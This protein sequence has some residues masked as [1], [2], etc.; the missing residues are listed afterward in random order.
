MHL[1]PL[2]LGVYLE[3]T[4]VADFRT[5]LAINLPQT[6]QNLQEL[7]IPRAPSDLYFSRSTLQNKA[8]FQS[9]QGAPFG[10]E[11]Y[12]YTIYYYLI[13]RVYICNENGRKGGWL[14]RCHPINYHRDLA[15]AYHV[16]SSNIRIS[17]H[18]FETLSTPQSY[19]SPSL[20]ASASCNPKGWWRNG[21]LWKAYKWP[22]V[23]WIIL[24]FPE[25]APCRTSS[26]TRRPSKRSERSSNPTLAGYYVS[27]R[28]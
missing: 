13:D 8:L 4:R 24:D 22:K 7:Y 21:K 3:A 6:N 26:G 5:N 16:S 2:L 1:K 10:F 14:K 9:K 12:I 27:F 28:E 23:D 19:L 17:W 15:T 20:Q 11:V 18:N 25:V